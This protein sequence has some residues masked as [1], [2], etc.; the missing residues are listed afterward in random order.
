MRLSARAF[1]SLTVEFKPSGILIANLSAFNMKEHEQEDFFD[2]RP[3]MFLPNHV[4]YK[5]LRLSLHT[6]RIKIE[7]ITYSW[8]I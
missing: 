2:I 5:T 8:A 4:T 7:N 1:E 3:P 6:Y